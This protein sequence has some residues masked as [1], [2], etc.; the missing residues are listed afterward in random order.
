MR[1][2]KVLLL[3]SI[4]PALPATGQPMS[5]RAFDCVMDPSS[6][7]ALSSPVT[8]LIDEVLVERGDPVTRGQVVARLVS[9]VE[10]AALGVL[11]TRAESDAA[12]E[13]LEIQRALVQSRYDRVQTLVERGVSS[14]DQLQVIEASLAAADSDLARARLERELARQELVRAE[15]QIEQRTIKSP[16]DGLVQSRTLSAGERIG[17]DGEIVTIVALDPLYVEAFLPVEMAPLIREGQ[18]ADIRPGLPIEGVFEATVQVIDRVFDAASSTFGVRLA[19]PNPDGDLPA[20][21]RCVL[22]F[23]QPAND[24]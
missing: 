23:P 24:G 12:V 4:L 9:D 7:V 18:S 10:R 3:S 8:G 19:L 17:T 6:T 16:I 2:L 21:H 15:A 11:R 13:A 20:G 14:T 1:I 22:S 5:E